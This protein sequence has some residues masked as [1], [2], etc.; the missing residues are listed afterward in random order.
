MTAIWLAPAKINLTLHVLGRRAD[1]YHL[2]DS[3]VAF[4]DIGDEL[5]AKP[6]DTLSLGINGPFAK[7]LTVG[8]DNL[9]MRAARLLNHDAGRGAALTLTKNLPIASGIGGGSSGAATTLLALAQLWNISADWHGAKLTTALGADVPVCL[10]RRP[11]R[12]QGIGELLSDAPALPRCG[13]VLVNPGQ[14]LS[15][16]EVFRAFGGPMAPAPALPTQ[17]SELR[18]LIGYLK[19]GDNALTTAATSIVPA[20][21]DVLAAVRQQPA[22]AL[23]R[24]SGSGPTCFGVFPDRTRAAA[25][26]RTLAAQA[27]AWWVEHG[28][29]KPIAAEPT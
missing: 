24:L 16:P 18:D 9:V 27:P 7:G 21:A 20:I 6:A 22:C 19:A 26:A 17:F 23:A 5:V 12:L 11:T 15:T 28:E 29:L 4:A 13:V 3:L 1:G 14:P 2:L 8:E 25:A 10:R